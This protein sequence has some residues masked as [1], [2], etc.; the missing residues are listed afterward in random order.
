MAQKIWLSGSRG[1]VGNYTKTFLKESGHHVTS[2]SQSNGDSLQLLDFSNPQEITDLIKKEGLP[3]TFIH[4]GW[5]KV[6]EPHDKIHLE[7]NLEEGKNLIET[8]FQAGLSRFILVGSS[9]EYGDLEGSL[10]ESS[11]LPEA[12]NNYIKGKLA[13]CNFGMKRA[14]EKEAI[15]IHTRLYYAYGA[16][17]QH[18]SLINQLF[19]NSRN[20]TEMSLSPCEHYRD[21]IYIEDVA[22]GLEKICQ[23]NESV[24]I[25]LGGG[26]VIK[27]KDFVKRFWAMTGS[28]FSKLHFGSHEQPESEQSQPKSYAN[29]DT[30]KNL[31]GWTP[32]TSIDSG[33][34]KTINL[35]S[36]K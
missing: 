35:L 4:L 10:K 27:L 3:D 12:S 28:E 16:G 29:L 21:Y 19:E 18:N 8:L 22:K 14:Q 13:L 24:I 26:S 20:G 36:S 17:Q 32:E 5:G 33:I 7:E 23:L 31:T 34:E 6:Y 15:F 1:F 9:S 25:N 30:L 2:V 11:E